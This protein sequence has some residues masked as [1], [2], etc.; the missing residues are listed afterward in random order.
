[1][2]S[3]EAHIFINDVLIGYWPTWKFTPAQTSAWVRKLY[4]Y[5]FA[6]AKACVEGLYTRWEKQGKPGAGQIFQALNQAVIPRGEEDSGDPVQ[7]YNIIRPDG[8]RAGFPVSSAKGVPRDV[9]GV[10]REAEEL[11]KRI[12]RDREGYYIQWIEPSIAP[13]VPF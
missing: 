5:D 1:M 12:A 7:L 4:R 2:N 8:K 6:K 11:L 10:R 9:E 13:Q 3:D